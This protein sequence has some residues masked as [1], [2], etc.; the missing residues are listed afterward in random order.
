MIT[1]KT[2]HEVHSARS[3]L[4]IRRD[5][6]TNFWVTFTRNE[7]NGVIP[8]RFA[9]RAGFSAGAELCLELG[10]ECENYGRQWVILSS[11]E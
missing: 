4:L 3:Q 2:R 8:V 1:Q 9:E 6:S 10:L 7:T 11:A 5:A